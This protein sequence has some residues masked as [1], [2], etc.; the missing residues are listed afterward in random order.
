[1]GT[2]GGAPT[3]GSDPPPLASTLRNWWLGV[4][5]LVIGC[6]PGSEQRDPAHVAA[7]LLAVDGDLVTLIALPTRPLHHRCEPHRVD[8]RL[9]PLGYASA[10]GSADRR[11]THVL[12]RPPC[13]RWSCAR[14]RRR[15]QLTLRKISDDVFPR[16][17]G[18]AF[19]LRLACSG[20]Q[21]LRDGD[22]F[23]GTLVLRG[24]TP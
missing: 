23:A 18:A 9:L 11:L 20:P 13:E 22:A 8:G 7:L 1:M 3:G 14:P 21:L 10:R 16:I 17:F 19:F 12:V 6:S 15:R 5:W 4:G 2:L 24:L